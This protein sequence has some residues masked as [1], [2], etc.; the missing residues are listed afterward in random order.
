LSWR[1]ENE[2]SCP[3]RY[4]KREMDKAEIDESFISQLLD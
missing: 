1:R 4:F 3:E 2:H